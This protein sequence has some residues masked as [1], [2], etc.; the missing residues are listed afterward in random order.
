MHLIDVSNVNGRID[1][2]KVA[3]AGVHGA[4]IKATE[5][6]TFN[7]ALFDANRELAA[8]HGV[9]VGAYHFARPD[10]NRAVDEAR[11]FAGVVKRLKV[12]ELKPVLDYEVSSRMLPSTQAQWIRDFNHEVRRI[13]G[14]WPM[15]YTYPALLPSLRLAKP[16]G[17][18]LW[19][20][21]YGVNDGREHAVAV[22]APWR[23]IAVHQF[24]SRGHVPGVPGDVDISSTAS[25][26]SLL[27]H[28]VRGIAHHV[29][30]H[31]GVA[32]RAI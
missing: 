28:P 4:F 18:G 25:L 3:Q 17:N 10:N 20:A 5:G 22:P 32:H 26:A 8:R 15:F 24:T 27:A 31:G 19:L 11:H 30:R 16:V 2:A 21:S 29:I 23:R 1:W 7:D 14:V 12:G 9:H 13:L 6:R